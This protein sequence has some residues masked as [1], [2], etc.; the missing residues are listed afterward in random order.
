MARIPLVPSELGL[1]TTPNDGTG[2]QLRAGGQVIRDWMDD[3]NEMTAQLFSGRVSGTGRII[4]LGDS[5][6]AQHTVQY[7]PTAI[8]RSGSTVTVTIPSA[9]L[10]DGSLVYG[11]R[12]SDDEYNGFK[13]LTRVDT[14]TYTYTVT[15][16]P[17]SPATP[18]AAGSFSMSALARPADRG[19]FIWANMLLGWP[20]EIVH[21]AAMGGERTTALDG[22]IT[23]DV[24][25]YDADWVLVSFGINDIAADTSATTIIDNLTA[26]CARLL[27]DGRKVLLTTLVPL[28]YGSASYTV[29][30]AHAVMVVNRALIDYARVTPGV[31]LADLFGPMVDP[32][33]SIMTIKSGYG[34]GIHPYAIGGYA[35]G[36]Q[37][38][39]DFA[40]V[41]PLQLGLPQSAVE[42]WTVNNTERQI[43]ANPLFQGAS[44]TLSGGP[45]GTVATGWTLLQSGTLTVVGSV[46]A[47]ADGIGNDQVI[48]CS[49]GSGTSN[50]YLY[51]TTNLSGRV[52]A[53]DQI[54]SIV[55]ISVSGLTALRTIQSTL[56]STINGNAATL[57]AGLIGDATTFPQGDMTI[58]LRSP[59]ITVPAGSITNLLHQIQF[60]FNAGGAGVL[61]VGRIGVY[62]LT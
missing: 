54:F 1:G 35:I 7:T 5:I 57:G 49:G 16:T 18:G 60:V 44:G 12:A 58:V 43:C 20:F 17:V 10:P 2:S 13:V 62:K 28:H 32:A 8:T 48:T 41:F 22:H 9:N 39:T 36:K 25:P 23:R 6:T 4:L 34:D 42:D 45:T 29:A 3:I 37:F 53:G 11:M 47:R 33:Q 14:S 61:K 21:N 27:A 55:E 40:D 59:A 52:S 56:P 24:L 50:V 26:G 15:G 19:W 30:R 31:Y 38:A 51:N 46:E